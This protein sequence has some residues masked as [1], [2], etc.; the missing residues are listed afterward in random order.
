LQPRVLQD[1]RERVGGASLREKVA[2][3]RLEFALVKLFHDRLEALEAA[4]LGPQKLDP[5][6][7]NKSKVPDSEATPLNG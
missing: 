3:G 5:T 4:I 6:N 2:L 7:Y 1:G